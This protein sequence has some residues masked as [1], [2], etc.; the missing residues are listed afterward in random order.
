[1]KMHKKTIKK[2]KSNTFVGS[3]RMTKLPTMDNKEGLSKDLTMEEEILV[4]NED[5]HVTEY[6]P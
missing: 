4:I 3:E 2:P 1:M 6:A 5:V